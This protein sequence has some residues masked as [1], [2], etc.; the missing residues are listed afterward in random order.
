VKSAERSLRRLARGGLLSHASALA[1]LFVGTLLVASALAQLPPAPVEVHHIHGLALDRRDPEVLYVATHTGLVRLRP[2]AAPEW[3]GSFF[4][5][6]GFT[7]HSTEAGLLFASGHP[8]LATYR[9]QKVGNLGLLVSRDGGRTWR[10][11]ALQGAADFHALAYHPGNGGEL[12]GWSVAERPGLYRIPTTSWVAEPIRAVRL[13]DVL[14]LAASPDPGG[15]LLAGTKTGLFVSRSRGATWARVETISTAPVTTLAYHATDGRVVYLYLAPP[16][17]GLLRSRNG[18]SAWE[19]VDGAVPAGSVGVALAVGPG[20]H[21][22][23]ATS[24]ADILR[25]RDGGRTWKPMLEQGR[26]VSRP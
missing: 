10:S 12:Y 22:V 1:G 2:N 14:T 8:D 23:V 3:A 7:A 21:V 25:S 19:A 13:V 18:G 17:R 11:V 9:G 16:G 6:M 15:P 5:L 24:K 4:D 26:P 20:D